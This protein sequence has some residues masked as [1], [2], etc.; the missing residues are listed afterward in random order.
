MVET[1]K[2]PALLRCETLYAISFTVLVISKLF[3]GST[4]LSELFGKQITERISDILF[5]VSL[6]LLGGIALHHQYPKKGFILLLLAFGTLCLSYLI[7][8]PTHVIITV[9]YLY[10]SDAIKN[11]RRFTWY[12]CILYAAVILT[13]AMLSITGVI[14]TSIKERNNIDAVGYSLGF[15]HA[16]MVAVLLYSVICLV[17]SL[18]MDRKWYEKLVAYAV[19]VCMMIIGFFITRSLSYLLLCLILLMGFFCHD[20]ILCKLT[21]PKKTTRR[22]IRLGLLIVGGTVAI[23]VAYFWKN[24]SLL[25]GSLKTFRARFILSQKY[26]RAYG[27]KLFGT[28]IVVGD[29]V[30]IPGYPA[31]YYYLDN[32]YIRLLVECGLLNMILVVCFMLRTINNLIKAAKWPLLL[33]MLSLLAYLFNEWKVISLYFTPAWILLSP[34][35]RAPVKPRVKDMTVIITQRDAPPTRDGG[36]G[37]YGTGD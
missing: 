27:I 12:L 4:Y 29:N 8:R 19:A 6:L 10:Y 23:F 33:I 9:I 15:S 28:R 26:L 16:N 35:M 13:V 1:R 5:L 32:G 37:L 18:G 7:N 14:G 24:P 36:K 30:V 2:T 11:R 25:R 21:L 20:A 22:F 31:G 17:F 3:M 34:Y